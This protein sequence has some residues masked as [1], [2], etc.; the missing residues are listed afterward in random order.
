MFCFYTNSIS[1]H[2]LPLAKAL[3]HVL[4]E[5]NYRYVYTSPLTTERKLMGWS[6]NSQERWIISEQEHSLEA[7]TLLLKCDALLSG[8]RTLDVFE[9]RA[10]AGRL[11]MYFSE[12]WFKPIRLFSFSFFGI[13]I[14]VRIPGIV[15]M[16]V[17]SYRK[18]ARKLVRLINE[19]DNFYYLPAGVHAL[20][21]MRRIGAREEKMITW[22]YFVEQSEHKVPSITQQTLDLH[23]PLRLLWVGRMIG[24]KRVDTIIRAV[25]R[26]KEGVELTLVGSGEESARL[27][28]LVKGDNVHFVD[29]V[30]IARVR[31]V[32]RTHDVYVLS[33]DA[34][35]G[36]GAALSEALEEGLIGVGTYE[37]GSSATMLPDSQLFHAGDDKR[38]S[39]IIIAI[40]QS[41]SKKGYLHHIGV[42]NAIDGAKKLLEMR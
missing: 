24:W 9:A 14:N 33:S 4:G 35:E 8:N 18:M 13:K 3:I 1:P 37:A 29:S 10:M 21:D 31:D 38:L 16:L 2:Q 32:M 25:N 36:W 5:D 34:E 15:R 12:R 30:P 28:K 17:P 6:C 20:N 41:G 26:I 11:T 39:E 7:R 22:A 27:R 23:K 42:W 40:M 19:R